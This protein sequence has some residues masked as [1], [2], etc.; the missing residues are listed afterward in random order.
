MNLILNLR[1]YGA[2]V[3]NNTTAAGFIEWSDDRQ[4][5][6]YKGVQLN[7]NHLKWFL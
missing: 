3:W 2:V 1:A 7:M 5:V 6:S 4:D